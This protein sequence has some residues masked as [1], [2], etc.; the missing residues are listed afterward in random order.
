MHGEPDDKRTLKV[1]K[2]VICWVDHDD[3]GPKEARSLLENARFPNH[4]I[5][6]KV[7]ST[8]IREVEWDDDHPLNKRTTSQAEFEDLF[9]P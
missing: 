3:V 8:E 1:Y 2:M 7:M 5:G 9:K 4:I 6:P